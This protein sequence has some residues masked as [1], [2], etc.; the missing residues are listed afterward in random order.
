[1]AKIEAKTRVVLILR[2]KVSPSVVDARAK[3]HLIGLAGL[4]QTVRVKVDLK[5]R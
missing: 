1:M 3:V 4:K 5:L 2:F